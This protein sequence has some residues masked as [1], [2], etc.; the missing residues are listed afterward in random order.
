MY[1]LILPSSLCFSSSVSDN[2]DD[3]MSILL[4][5]SFNCSSAA[6]YSAFELSYSALAFSKSALA[7]LSLSSK[8]LIS[9]LSLSVSSKNAFTS[10]I[11]RSSFN[12][13]YCLAFSDC[14][15]NGPTCFSSSDKISL[16]LTRLF[17]SF[18]SFFCAVTLRLLNLTI[19]AASSNNSLRSS[20]FPL[21]ILSI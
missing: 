19:P 5:M 7:I 3:V 11:L 14:F 2:N 8:A 6:S 15:S 1:T 12:L 9:T 13:R 10:Y 4:L 18:S 17:L 20:G 21:S 16:T